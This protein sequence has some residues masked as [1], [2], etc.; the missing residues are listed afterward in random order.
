V[1]AEEIMKRM[2][3]GLPKLW[4]THCAL[5]LRRRKPEWF[6]ADAGYTPM[7]AEGPKKDHL[8]AYLRG[9][10]VVTCV[11]RWSAKLGGRWTATTVMLPPGHWKNVLTGE[12]LRGERIRIQILLQ[13]FP[14][15]LLAREA[16]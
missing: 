11:P 14:V 15:A 7:A 13:R 10:N 1:S 3:C 8:I 4:L 5:T 9:D 16:E 2:D 12:I 6:G